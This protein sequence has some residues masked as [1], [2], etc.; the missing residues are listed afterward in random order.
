M[1]G[2]YSNHSLA[3]FGVD[4]NFGHFIQTTKYTKHTKI[5]TNFYFVYFV[6]INIL[7]DLHWLILEPSP[8]IQVMK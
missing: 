5:L 6:V 2:G 7:Y 1:H 3:K 4:S 8:K